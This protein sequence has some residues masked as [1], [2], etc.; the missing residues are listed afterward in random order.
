ML[1]ATMFVQRCP[2]AVPSACACKERKKMLP[3]RLG[4]ERPDSGGELAVRPHSSSHVRYSQPAGVLGQRARHY[5]QASV[6]AVQRESRASARIGTSR[7][8]RLLGG[9]AREEQ[10]QQQRGRHA[11]CSGGAHHAPSLDKHSG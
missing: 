6:A 2:R 3:A 8:L 4:V 9:A 7:Q 11:G 10:A 1:A 5:A